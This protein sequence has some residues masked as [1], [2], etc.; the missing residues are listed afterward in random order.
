M[1]PFKKHNDIERI[2]NTSSQSIKDS[3]FIFMEVVVVNNRTDKKYLYTSENELGISWN[4]LDNFQLLVITQITGSA[5]NDWKVKAHLK[6]FSIL[7][8]K[9]A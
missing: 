1:W 2:E 7:S 8:F 4:Y 3:P 5:V 9:T 6:D